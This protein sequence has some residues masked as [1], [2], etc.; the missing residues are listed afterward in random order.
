MGGISSFPEVFALFDG[1]VS[2][3]IRH[4]RIH[5][6]Y[7]DNIHSAL[8]L[9]QRPEDLGDQETKTCAMDFDGVCSRLLHC[10]HTRISDNDICHDGVPSREHRNGTITLQS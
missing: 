3:T 7:D 4:L 6:V 1:K 10:L 2:G 8:R 5:G 9:L